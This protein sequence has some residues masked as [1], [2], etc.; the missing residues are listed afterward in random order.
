MLSPYSLPFVDCRGKVRRIQALA[1]GDRS[2]FLSLQKMALELISEQDFRVLYDDRDSLFPALVDE[3]LR[4]HAIV[5]TDVDA[6]MATRLLFGMGD[7][8][9]LLMQL[10]FP[11][12]EADP[13]AKPIPENLEPE[14]YHIAAL[15]GATESL[16]EAMFARDRVSFPLLQSVLK[17]RNYQIDVATGKQKEKEQ[18]ER[19]QEGMRRLVESGKMQQFLEAINERDKGGTV[20]VE[21]LPDDYL[22]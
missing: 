19:S 13:A 10:N 4:L 1:L 17:A 15:W 3:C 18:I 9:A 14:A 11:R 12:E 16:E 21:E 2:Y 7:E 22:F 6:Y 20:A 5:P 8:E